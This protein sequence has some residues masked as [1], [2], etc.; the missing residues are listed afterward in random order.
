MA[1][2][3]GPLITVS[4]FANQPRRR[5]DD[6]LRSDAF[7]LG[8][9]HGPRMMPRAGCGASVLRKRPERC[10]ATVP[11]LDT[12][13]FSASFEKRAPSVLSDVRSDGAQ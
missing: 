1:Q 9:R 2:W 7:C 3:L 13:R 12:A 6:G 11:G 10:A 4:G 5:A 8:H